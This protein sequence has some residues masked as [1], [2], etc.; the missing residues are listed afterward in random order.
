MHIIHE[1]ELRVIKTYVRATTITKKYNVLARYSFT[2]HAGHGD[3]RLSRDVF[4]SS[5]YNARVRVMR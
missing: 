1:A 5:K 2:R 4:V 3:P